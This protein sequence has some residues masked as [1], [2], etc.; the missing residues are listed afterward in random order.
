MP[1]HGRP[2]PTTPVDD[3]TDDAMSYLTAAAQGDVDLELVRAFVGDARRVADEIEQRTPIA[4]EV[5]EHWPDYRGE[6]PGAKAGGRSLWPRSLRLDPAIEARVQA[7]FDQPSQSLRD[8]PEPGPDAPANDGVVLRG[9]VRGRALVGGLLAALVDAGVEIRTGAHATRLVVEDG[10]VVGVVVDGHREP[11]RVVVASGGFQHD[12][13]LVEEYL[14][15]PPLVPMGAAGCAGDGLRMAPRSA[16]PWATR[17]RGG[18]CRPAMCRASSSRASP[19]SSA[20]QRAR[21]TRGPSWS[22]AA[23]VGSSTRPRTTATS[24]GPCGPRAPRWPVPRR[25][26]LAGLRRR[27]SP[28]LPDGAGRARRAPTPRGSPRADTSR[29]WRSP[30]ASVRAHWRPS[31]TRFNDGAA[32]GEDPDF[33]RGSFPYDR[34]IGDPCAPHPTLA[35]LSGPPSTRSSVHLG[36]MGTKGGPRTDDRGR[37][38]SSRRTPGGA[39][40]TRRATPRPARSARPR[41]PGGPRSVPRSSSASGP[42]RRRRATGEHHEP[43]RAHRGDCPTGRALV[44][45]LLDAE[46]RPVPAVLRATADAPILGTAVPRAR[47]LS[48]AVHELEVEK[49]WRRV[50]QMAC[51]QEQIPEVGDSSS[52]TSPASRSSCV[53]AGT[54]PDPRLP[55]LLPPPGH[56]SC[57]RSRAASANCAVPSTASPGTSTGPSPGCRVRGTSPMSTRTRSACP[58]PGWAPGAGSSS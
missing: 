56:A 57:A 37:V 13:A 22:T 29:S 58:R 3:S 33:G 53:R 51:R 41:R 11:G 16:P 32:V 34:W 21:P 43:P 8:G 2:G 15:G 12:A 17:P 48:R 10:V 26:V 19:F 28:P 44:Q 30:S 36:C 24:A 9:H 42:A 46:T 54:R 45:E 47:Y 18:G 52:T 1:A 20:P 4:W 49:V 35:P 27:L 7:A 40:S 50:W 25:P 23:V 14:P 55:Q 39:G 6:L 5:L 38:L 31:V